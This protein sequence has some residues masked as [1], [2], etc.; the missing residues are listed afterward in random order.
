MGTADG[1]L[2]PPLVF[3]HRQQHT[4]TLAKGDIPVSRTVDLECARI[5]VQYIFLYI[6]R[7][8]T[9]HCFWVTVFGLILFFSTGQS[10]NFNRLWQ[11]KYCCS[12]KLHELQGL[13]FCVHGNIYNEERVISQ[14]TGERQSPVLYKE[15]LYSNQNNMFVLLCAGSFPVTIFTKLVFWTYYNLQKSLFSIFK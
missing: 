6:P 15:V 10:Q 3:I 2:L 11:P 4:S 8:V 13:H 12:T 5:H 7:C 14:V 1:C 9:V